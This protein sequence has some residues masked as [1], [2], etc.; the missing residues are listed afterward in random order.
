MTDTQAL[1]RLL[2]YALA[3]A[4]SLDQDEVARHLLAAINKLAS[5]AEGPCDRG[6]G[7]GASS[8]ERPSGYLQ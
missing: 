4:R 8:A 2:A 7:D 5:K 1:R 6:S 3:E